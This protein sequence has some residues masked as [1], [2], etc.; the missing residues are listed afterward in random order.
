MHGYHQSVILDCEA[1]MN[2]NPQSR[3]PTIRLSTALLLVVI[4]A[5]AIALAIQSR[6]L[7][8]MTDR[9][10]GREAAI[11]YLE[12]EAAYMEAQAAAAGQAQRPSASEPPARQTA[13]E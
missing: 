9:A 5:L 13:T 1:V 12:A 11:R 10:S 3:R 4:A 2:T 6:R 8:V 7:A